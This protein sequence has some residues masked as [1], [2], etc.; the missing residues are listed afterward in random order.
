MTAKTLT[1]TKKLSPKT[2]VIKKKFSKKEL[3][4]YRERLLNLKDDILEQI[5]EISEDTIMKSQKEMSGDIS[6]YGI[7]IAD[8]ATDNYERDFNLNLV[9]NERRIIMQIDEALK[10]I[11]DGTYGICQMSGKPISKSRLK[12]I[13][14]AKYSKKCKEK[15]EKE[16]KM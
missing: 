4:F 7:H 3:K 15:I 1:N 12:A 6:G 10:R 8:V 14:Y 11:E 9:S 5:R 2:K 16:N 13:P